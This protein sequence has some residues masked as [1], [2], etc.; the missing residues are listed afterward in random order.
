MVPCEARAPVLLRHSPGMTVA[1][2]VH[3]TVA[4]NV[5]HLRTGRSPVPRLRIDRRARLRRGTVRAIRARLDVVL[6]EEGPRGALPPPA[7]VRTVRPPLCEP[8]PDLRVP[9]R[10]VPPSGLRERRGGP[11]RRGDLR[12]GCRDH[13]SEAS[14]PSRAADIGAGDGAFL[15]R[16]RDAGFEETVGFEPSEAPLAAA[17]ASVRDSIRPEPFSARVLPDESFTLISCMQTIEHVLDPLEVCRDA[18]RALAPRGAVLIACHDRRAFT[19]RVLKQRSPIFDIEHVQLFSPRSMSAL[20]RLAGLERIEVRPLRNRYPLRYWLQ[21]AP[22]PEASGRRSGEC[23]GRAAR[24]PARQ[25]RRRESRGGGLQARRVGVADGHAASG[26]RTRRFARGAGTG[27]KHGDRRW[28]NGA[29]KPGRA[30]M[31][32]AV[33]PRLSERAQQFLAPRGVRGVEIVEQ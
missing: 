24:R 22:I 8:G 6:V 12:E 31:T 9:D 5:D 30:L 18:V 23:S 14:G 19:A 25:P 13:R 4:R 7:R 1:P 33:T 16:L 21:L 29:E 17:P 11:V 2:T 3:T 10:R 28:P 15:E 20:L 27:T 26:P 32:I